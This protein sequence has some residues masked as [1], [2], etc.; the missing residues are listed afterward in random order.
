MGIKKQAIKKVVPK[1]E[2][3]YFDHI[4]SFKAEMVW[5]LDELAQER[6]KLR[7]MINPPKH[8]LNRRQCVDLAE[9]LIKV[10]EYA[11]CHYP[12]GLKDY[13]NTSKTRKKLR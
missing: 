10:V 11:D 3:F 2:T 12:N 9:W 5:L 8:G 6:P 4:V 1:P 13:F 7:I